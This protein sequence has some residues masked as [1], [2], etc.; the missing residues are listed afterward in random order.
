LDSGPRPFSFSMPTRTRVS[1]E[2]DPVIRPIDGTGPLSESSSKAAKL[3]QF[4]LVTFD[5]CLVLLQVPK[6][7]GLVQIF[8]A[9]P[10]VYLH[11]VAVTNILC[12]TKNDLHSAKLYFVAGQKFFKGH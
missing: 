6:C 4:R 2:A 10:K 1:M 5:L 7:F 9:K 12:Q 3:Q 8:C 11:I